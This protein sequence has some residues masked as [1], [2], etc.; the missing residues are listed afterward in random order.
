MSS[1]YFAITNDGNH[2][3]N[4]RRIRQ[5]LLLVITLTL[6]VY[7]IAGHFDLAERYINWTALGEIYQLDEIVFVLLASCLG[8]I[9]F[10]LRRI[11]ELHSSLRHNITMQCSLQQTNQHIEQL[12]D[13]K[14]Q[15]VKHLVKARESER[16]HLATELH[17]VFG[18]YLAAMDANLTV[19]LQLA[20]EDKLVSSL[21]AV[22]ESTTH[23]RQLTREKL[24]QLKPPL[25]HSIGLSGAI[26][27]LINDWQR[28]HPHCF[29]KLALNIDDTNTVL[30][31]AIALTLYRAIQEGLNCMSNN[32]IQITITLT[33]SVGSHR[34]Y[35]KIKN[36]YILSE[37]LENELGLIGI[38]ERTEALDGEFH[39]QTIKPTDSLMIITIPK[40]LTAKANL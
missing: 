12:L 28:D 1:S 25:L 33:D 34:L 13:H 2:V 22:L 39:L 11:K 14:R 32:A 29:L 21:K 31:E 10:S 36:Q 37:Q 4:H 8:L 17:D 27:E 18:Q 19:A 30:N 40:Q 5:D 16:Q 9:W 23:L 20:T 7:V 38:R 3:M 26:K 15:L 24:Q 35:L 6:L